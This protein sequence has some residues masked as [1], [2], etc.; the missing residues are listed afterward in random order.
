MFSPF[1]R[2]PRGSAAWFNAGPVSSFP[3]IETD[4]GPL[5]QQRKCHDAFAPGCKVFHV[6]R[7]DA[8]SAT[9]VAIDDWK[10]GE[11]DTKDQV[12]VFRYSGSVVAVNHECPHA[13]YPLSNGT[14]F[15]IEDFGV[16]LSAGI[17][18]P[19]HDWSFDLHTGKSDRGSYKLAIWET[20]LRKSTSGE[21][22]VWVRRKQRIG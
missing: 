13:S 3:D 11:T 22:E 1:S 7:E 20:Q 2:A 8:T 16:K 19:K 5:G 14:P 21:E 15:D 4:P 9:P 18:C 6:P 10:D 12:M 17:T